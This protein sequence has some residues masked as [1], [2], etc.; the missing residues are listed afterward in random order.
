MLTWLKC[1]AD[2]TKCSI[3][4]RKIEAVMPHLQYLSLGLAGFRGGS[5]GNGG[6]WGRKQKGKGQGG[7]K[8]NGSREGDEKGKQ[9]RAFTTVSILFCFCHR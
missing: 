5:Q 1:C 9:E 7:K 8:N 2:C 3:S 4:N 6:N